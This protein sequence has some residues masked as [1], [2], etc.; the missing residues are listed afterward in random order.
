MTPPQARNRRADALRSRASVL[1]AALP[2]LNAHP[3]ASMEAV[4]TAADVTR[5]TVYA[6]FRSRELLLA[7]VI[8]RITEEAVAAMDAADPDT[9]PAGEALLRLLDAGARTA[10][11]YPVLLQ[12]ISSL[13][14]SPQAD[15]ERHTPVTDRLKR[16]IR[17]GQQTGEFD[18]RLSPDWLATV[19]IKIAHAASEEIDTGRMSRKEAAQALHTTLLR[20]LGATTPTLATPPPD[21]IGNHSGSPRR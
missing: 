15:H 18:D 8:D 9:G 2:L 3:D 4:A 20:A 5:Q 10:G 7:A 12:K 21:Q 19:T 16:V 6:H 13:A 1:D 17:R 14:V 11:R